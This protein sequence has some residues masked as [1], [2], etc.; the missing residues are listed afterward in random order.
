MNFNFGSRS[1]KREIRALVL[2]AALMLCLAAASC[3]EAGMGTAQQNSLNQPKSMSTLSQ[4]DS[5]NKNFQPEVLFKGPKSVEITNIA[6]DSLVNSNPLDISGMADPGTV[7]SINDEIAAVGKDR[8]FT[9]SVKLDE[10]LN[11]LEINASDPQ[12]DQETAYLTV[13]YESQH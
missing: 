2:F 5:S 4:Q 7:I 3:S 1:Q 8:M 13:T 12:G 10:G 11:V 6:D 9:V